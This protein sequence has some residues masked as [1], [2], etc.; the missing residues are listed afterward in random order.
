[1]LHIVLSD[2]FKFQ[3]FLK[4]QFLELFHSLIQEVSVLSLPTCSYY[5]LQEK[6]LII[7]N[8]YVMTEMIYQV[9]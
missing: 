7:R 5:W 6:I 3:Y 1:V 9:S 8:W 2:I 4:V